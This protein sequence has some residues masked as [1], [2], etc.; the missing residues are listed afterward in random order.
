MKDVISANPEANYLGVDI[1]KAVID[2]NK[3]KY[4]SPKLTFKT[5]NILGAIPKVDLVISRDVLV[6]LL[7]KDVQR[8]I[9]SFRNSESHYLL[10][11]SFTDERV[12]K[13]HFDGICEWCP[14]N[15][16]KEPFNLPEPLEIIKE[17]SQ[18][19]DHPYRDKSL[20]LWSREQLQ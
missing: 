14:I 20:L 10:M 11:T 13:E 8:F 9:Q 2:S 16:R 6:H 7:F 5:G 3:R 4:P 1:V 12:N 18:L 17:K 15:F 19:I